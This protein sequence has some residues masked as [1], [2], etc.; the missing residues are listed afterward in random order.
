M[1]ELIKELDEELD[2]LLKEDDLYIM[3]EFFDLLAL[4]KNQKAL[5][6]DLFQVNIELKYDNFRNIEE[7]GKGEFSVVY[8]SSY[9]R[10]DGT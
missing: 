6:E 9:R 1:E 7:V 4:K 8:E 2:I 5:N 3:K 10:Q